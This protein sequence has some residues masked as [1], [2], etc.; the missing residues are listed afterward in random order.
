MT[1]KRT[2][3][4]RITDQ[5]RNRTRL[6][7][8][9]IAADADLREWDVA[10]QIANEAREVHPELGDVNIVLWAKESLLPDGFPIP[11][12]SDRDPHGDDRAPSEAALYSFASPAKQDLA[13]RARADALSRRDEAAAHI[14]IQAAVNVVAR[15]D[16]EEA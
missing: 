5:T 10:Q 1:D 9:H 15:L 12:P 14:T 6:A 13:A 8:G 16:A 3:A 7:A 11:W 2:W 4:W